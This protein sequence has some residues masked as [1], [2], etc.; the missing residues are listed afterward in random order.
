MWRWPS[1]PRRDSTASADQKTSCT[2]VTLAAYQE[3]LRSK[4][5]RRI[6]CA[7]AQAPRSRNSTNATQPRPFHPN[8]ALQIVSSRAF[9]NDAG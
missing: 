2:T 5:L 6:H 7:V 1:E 9:T 3:K 8:L 4:T